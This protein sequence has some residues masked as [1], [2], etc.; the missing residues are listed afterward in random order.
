MSNAAYGLLGAP[1][2]MA[3]LP[4]FVQLPAYYATHLGMALAPLGVVLFIARGIDMLQDPLLGHLL[5]R[6]PA[7]RKRWMTLGAGALM[8]AF[9]ALWLPPA[10]VPTGWWLAVMLVLAYG[11]HSL[12]NIA[13]LA[14]GARLPAALGGAAW[15][16]GLGL[17]GML[18]ASLIPAAILAGDPAQIRAR[19]TV[20][21]I[22]FA[23][24]MAAAIG[25]LL[26]YAPAPQPPTATGEGSAPDATAET[27]MVAAM[28]QAGAGG[29][30][31]ESWLAPWRELARSR[32]VR[33]LLLPYFFNA[34]AVAIPA[35]LALF[36]IADQLG[37][38][39][40]SGIFLACYF[41]A[42]A[43]G[44]PAWTALAR[45]WGPLRC[46][47]LGMLLSVAGFCGAALLG[48]GDLVPYAIVCVAAGAALGADLALPPVLLGQAL[49]EQ[50]SNR[51]GAG[52]GL[53][54]LLGKLALAI[55]GLTLPLLAWLDYRPGHGGGPALV[56]AYAIIPCLLKLLAMATS[57]RKTAR[58]HP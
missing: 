9:A 58:S 31:R 22:A 7:R 21:S 2:A 40:L 42:A 5:D 20:Y 43:C 47:R 27:S 25:A 32:A 44:L 3:A 33:A 48:Q 26:R 34:L 37:A 11:A 52:F 19:L 45:K 16:E 56:A 17:A 13:Y 24:L 29:G 57:G 1:L 23:L 39:Q 50:L 35:T 14:W 15:R 18:S 46:W 8:L 6:T 4:L 12:V 36:Y 53:F 51:L 49:G 10:G 38:P 28:P 54:T 30:G 55:A 41:G